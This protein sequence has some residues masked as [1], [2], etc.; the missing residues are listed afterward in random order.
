MESILTSINSLSDPWLSSA[1]QPH[2]FA[3]PAGTHLIILG[4]TFFF[5]SEQGQY[6]PA[7]ALLRPGPG[8]WSGGS[9]G[10]AGLNLEEDIHI[11]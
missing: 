1:S 11:F 2:I 9:G 4:C 8:Y 5:L 10:T 3:N 6:F 7:W